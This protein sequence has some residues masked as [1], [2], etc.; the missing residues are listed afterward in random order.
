MSDAELS[1]M[2]EGE[3][4]DDHYQPPRLRILHFLIWTAVTAVLL[5]FNVAITA[6]QQAPTGGSVAVQAVSSA[7][8][9]LL[10]AGFVGLGVMVVSRLRGSPGRLQPGH[11]ILV[12]EASVHAC[13]LPL[14]LAFFFIQA[15]RELK[16]SVLWFSI[17]S[18]GLF[19]L[20]VLVRGGLYLLAAHRTRDDLRW[21]ATFTILGL[22]AL[23][24]AIA[25]GWYA[26]N[27][28]HLAYAFSDYIFWAQF[29]ICLHPV[30]VLIVSL[31]AIIGG[32]RA[33]RDWLHWLGLA[34]LGGMAALQIARQLI[35]AFLVHP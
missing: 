12:A 15:A 6:T 16:S 29:V 4:V 19:S 14:S 3:L 33:G 34:M 21:K 7:W 31:V 9:I 32:L 2:T 20:A 26:L 18:F 1:R 25:Y 17:A 30:V 27:L 24:L 35:F 23:L 8:S 5:K 10:A 13:T 28:S 11:W 22:M